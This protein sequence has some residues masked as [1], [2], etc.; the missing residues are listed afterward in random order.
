MKFSKA[1]EWEKPKSHSLETSLSGIVCLCWNCDAEHSVMCF[2]GSAQS[3][4]AILLFLK[5]KE[6]VDIM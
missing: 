6:C 1:A 2:A 5:S 4:T 3:K